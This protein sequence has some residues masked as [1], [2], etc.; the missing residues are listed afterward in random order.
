MGQQEYHG[1]PVVGKAVS[2]TCSPQQ[3][4]G[5]QTTD[6]VVELKFTKKERYALSEPG[7]PKVGDADF[8]IPSRSD[9]E[10]AGMK[11]GPV[12]GPSNFV[13]QSLAG[14]STGRQVKQVATDTPS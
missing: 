11:K 2:S 3:L 10:L 1:L 12:L 4:F 9:R 6:C 7:S 8:G 13:P 5:K 14:A